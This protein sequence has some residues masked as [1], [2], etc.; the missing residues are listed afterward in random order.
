[1][2]IK[3]TDLSALEGF[4]SKELAQHRKQG[5]RQ[6]APEVRTLSVSMSG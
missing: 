4:F 2:I 5:A 3:D 6:G 1:M